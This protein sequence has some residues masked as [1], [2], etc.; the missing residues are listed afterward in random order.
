MRCRPCRQCTNCPSLYLQ[1]CTSRTS[2]NVDIFTVSSEFLKPNP[3][4]VT[5]TSYE[6]RYQLDAK[7]GFFLGTFSNISKLRKI[8]KAEFLAIWPEFFGVWAEFFRSLFSKFISKLRKTGVSGE[9]IWVFWRKPEFF[10]T[11]VF[12]K[13]PKKKP[14]NYQRKGQTISN[15]LGVL[16]FSTEYYTNLCY[17][18]TS[19]MDMVNSINCLTDKKVIHNLVYILVLSNSKPF[20]SHI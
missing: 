10:S 9:N 19:S 3:P 1:G 5:T 4:D 15:F 8:P 11:W 14:G 12:F 17:S 2:S 16:S 20:Y 18:K 7:A 13:M 6:S